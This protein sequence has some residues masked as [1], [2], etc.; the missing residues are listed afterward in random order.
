MKK[1]GLKDVKRRNRQVILDAVMESQ[2]LSR[3]EIAQKTSLAASTVS[4]L[5]NELLADGILAEAGTVETAGRSRTALTVNP[6]YG[7]IAVVVISRREIRMTCFDLRLQP[8][9]TAILSKQF[10]CGNDLLTLIDKCIRKWEKVIPPLA[11]MGLLFQEDMRESDFRVMYSTGLSSASITLR[12]ALVTQY[13]VPVE[14]E[15][16]LVYTVTDAL[17]RETNLDINNSAHISIGSRV[18]AQITLDGREIPVRSDFCD[19]LMPAL[20]QA[21]PERGLTEP[22]QLIPFLANLI[23]LLCT[24]FPLDTVILSGSRIPSAE[25]AEELRREVVQKAPHGQLPQLR[26]VPSNSSGDGTKAL[27][28]QVL[29]KA[30]VTR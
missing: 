8:V 14:E 12:E 9:K 29:K 10:V 11:G 20:S 15:Y 4:A 2:G 25:A 30:L 27:A 17:A 18:L 3:V 19:E 6:A 16:S 24:L 22:T 5:V 21:D 26:F 13:R 23:A 28:L 7:S 1:R